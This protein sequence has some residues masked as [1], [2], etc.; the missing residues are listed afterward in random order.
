MI[1]LFMILTAAAS[2]LHG[3]DYL[4]KWAVVAL[5]VIGS[6][7]CGPFAPIGAIVFWVFFRRGWQA[8]AELNYLG[9]K[10]SSLPIRKAYLPPFGIVMQKAMEWCQKHPFPDFGTETT[11][12]QQELVSGFIIGA[13]IGFPLLIVTKIVGF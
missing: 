10:A 4:P 2:A 12:R 5:H 11:R 6:Y 9:G 1:L 7:V 3:G 8:K 13:I